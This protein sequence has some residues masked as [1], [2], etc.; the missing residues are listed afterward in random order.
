MG[1]NMVETE[2]EFCFN[3][4][5]PTM[6]VVDA[7]AIVVVRFVIIH[8]HPFT[9]V[10]TLFFCTNETLPCGLNEQFFVSAV[11][12]TYISFVICSIIN[13]LTA[14]GAAS[15]RSL[16]RHFCAFAMLIVIPQERRTLSTLETIAFSSNY[17]L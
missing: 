11:G 7:N 10:A 12:S 5:G 3:T 4:S 8:S 2:C 15:S 16:A 17:H 9:F 13:R 14:G 6:A 1:K